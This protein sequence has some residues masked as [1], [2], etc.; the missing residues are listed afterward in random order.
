MDEASRPFTAFHVIGQPKLQWTRSPMGLAGS[1]STFSKLMDNEPINAEVP[2]ETN[3]QHAEEP[4]IDNEK[5]KNDESKPDE[6][7]KGRTKTT[8]KVRFTGNPSPKDK[9]S[10]LRHDQRNGTPAQ[11]IWAGRA[12]QP[13]WF[14][15]PDTTTPIKPPPPPP[16][17]PP[18]PIPKT[19]Q[20]SPNKPKTTNTIKFMTNMRQQAAEQAKIRREAATAAKNKTVSESHATKAPKHTRHRSEDLIRLATKPKTTPTAAQQA[21]TTR[22]LSAPKISDGPTDRV[23]NA[24]ASSLMGPPAP[25]RCSARLAHIPPSDLPLVPVKPPEY[26]DRAKKK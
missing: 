19:N 10:D 25:H 3:P 26:K 16:P 2:T 18:R 13:T 17:M 20:T 4:H 22:R 6:S 24:A 23:M 21:A 14:T 1:G 7:S 11:N 12:L 8:L 9:I 15:K 5:D